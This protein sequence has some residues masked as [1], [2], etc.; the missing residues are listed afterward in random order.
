M[1]ERERA[2]AVGSLALQ[3]HGAVTQADCTWMGQES[4]ERRDYGTATV[5]GIKQSL[6]ATASAKGATG[7]GL[8]LLTLKSGIDLH[9]AP[10]SSRPQGTHITP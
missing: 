2:Q 5:W 10:L 4:E 9:L 1:A 8:P 6:S 7:V 3:K